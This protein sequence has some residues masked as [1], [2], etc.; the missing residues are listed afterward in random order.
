MIGGAE[1]RIAG[2]ILHLLPERAVYWQDR[3]MLL[4]ADLH[5]GKAATFRSAGLFVP[6][7]TTGAGLDRLDQLIDGLSVERIVFL[8]DLLHARE[9]RAPRTLARLAEWR[10]AHP[11]LEL[12]LVRGNHDR[13]AGDPPD[14]LAIECV[15]EPLPV[16]PFALSHFPRPVAGSYVL[17][18]HIHPAVRL[19]GRGRQRTRLPCFWFGP[20]V[21]VLPAFGEFTGTGPVE[22]A[23]GDGVW[24]VAGDQVLEIESPGN[25]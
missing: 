21:A 15:D 22:P 5:W 14:E 2:E 1:A 11:D 20:D 10:A 23:P 17:A 25:S 16:G 24:V 13:G 6:R 19:I 18:G 9:G 12:T 8:G 7:G 4:V 3:R